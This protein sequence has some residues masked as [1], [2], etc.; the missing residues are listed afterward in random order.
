MLF[1]IKWQ[2]YFDW[3]GC[4]ESSDN[5]MFDYLYVERSGKMFLNDGLKKSAKTSFIKPTAVLGLNP[6]SLTP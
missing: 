1:R 4:V 3:L 2:D 6:G 5:V